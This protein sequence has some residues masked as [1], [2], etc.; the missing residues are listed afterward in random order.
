MATKV[1]IIGTLP[2]FASNEMPL[3][4]LS[5]GFVLFS[6]APFLLLLLGL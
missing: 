2:D 5:R 4:F 3:Y 1:G 6:Y